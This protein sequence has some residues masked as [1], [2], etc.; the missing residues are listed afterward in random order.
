[1]HLKVDKVSLISQTAKVVREALAAGEWSDWLPSERNIANDLGVGRN[2]LRAALKILEAEGLLY[3]VPRQGIRLARKAGKPAAKRNLVVGVLSPSSIEVAYP[4]KIIWIDALREQLARDGYMLKYYY[5]NQFSRVGFERAIQRLVKQERCDCWMLVA[6]THAVQEWFR[7][8]GIPCQIAGSCHPGV[9][10][11]F[12]DID[13]RAVCRHAVMTFRRQGHVNIVYV[14]PPPQLAGDICS[15]TGFLEGLKDCPGFDRASGGIE[16]MESA[17]DYTGPAVHRLMKKVPRP[18]AL[19]LNNPF[20]YLAVFS[21]LTKLGIRIPEEVSLICRG[22]DH[23][24]SY[25][26]P[27]PARYVQN[28]VQ[29]SGKLFQSIKKLINNLPLNERGIFLMPDF[30]EGGSVSQ[31]RS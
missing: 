15:E 3:S 1:M 9:D 8:N 28:P 17:V 12:V 20:Q 31:L 19:L 7:N 26:T 24:L 30:V 21:T 10:L 29:F 23:F 5:G 2:T 4:R 6:S 16:Y 22:A 18:T 14:T 27:T 25:L 11:P 13:Y